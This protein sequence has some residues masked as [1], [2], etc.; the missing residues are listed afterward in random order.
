MK[1]LRM[2]FTHRDR[3]RGAVALLV[4]VMWTTLFGMAVVAVDFGYLYTK[5]RNMQS[6]ADGALKA[7]MPV[8]MANGGG[9]SG[10]TAANLALARAQAV[11]LMSGYQ[12]AEVTALPSMPASQF[13]I[14]IQRSHPTFFGGLFGIGTKDLKAQAT[15][16]LTGGSGGAAIWAGDPS[17]CG[18]NW[19]LNTGL[20]I[21]GNGYLTVNGDVQSKNKIHFGNPNP[22]CNNPTVC[23]VTGTVTSGSGCMFFND[24]GVGPVGA[25]TVGGTGS[26][27][28][29]DPINQTFLA[30]N[31]KCTVGTMFM[32]LGGLPF[33]PEVAGCNPLPSAVYCSSTT[34]QVIPFGPAGSICPVAASFFSAADIQIMTNGTVDLTPHP[35][36]L[37]IVFFSNQIFGGPTAIFMS[38]GA[39]GTVQIR[40]AVYAPGGRIDFGTDTTNLLVGGT[41]A[42]RVVNIALGN[43]ASWIFN[44]GG[45]GGGS[46]W[47]IRF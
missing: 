6:I 10:S 40:G 37:G 45:G 39:G 15:G 4:A 20:D 22:L 19:D 42:G 9:A 47:R 11:A 31:S 24:P 27:S 8:F 17:A 12:N 33:G 43:G 7:A 23:Q 21:R 14:K 29:A 36:A 30:L 41:L 34:I 18:G 3:E 2:T 46:G 25:T 13:G 26:G 32:P 16:E 28:P 35:N 38:A 44:G 1:K 5:K